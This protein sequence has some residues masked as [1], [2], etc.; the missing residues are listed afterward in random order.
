MFD[1]LDVDSGQAKVGIVPYSTKPFKPQGLNKY[2]TNA[3]LRSGMEKTKYKRGR[4]ATGML[5]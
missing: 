3:A 1:Q 5:E 2:K 4:T